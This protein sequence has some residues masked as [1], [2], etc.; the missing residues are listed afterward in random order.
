MGAPV[1]AGYMLS[2]ADAEVWI[3]KKG[4]HL[5]EDGL[6]GRCI[7]QNWEK[8]GPD[9]S[10]DV[11]S[12][13]WPKAKFKRVLDENGQVVRHQLVRT[14]N[15]IVMIVRVTGYDKKATASSCI[16]VE[17]RESDRQQKAI[18]EG[19]HGIE[20]KWVVVPDPFMRLPFDC[21]E[22]VPEDYYRRGSERVFVNVE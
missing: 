21:V 9:A 11:M 22:D 10:G 7:R 19:T 2:Y 18:L 13:D 14:A 17:E 15:P 1:Y 16:W 12:T 5:A 20:W 4:W 8:L 3:E 6:V